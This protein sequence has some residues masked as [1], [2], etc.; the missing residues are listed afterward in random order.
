MNSV[1]CLSG[2]K[3]QSQAMRTSSTKNLKNNSG[4]ESSLSKDSLY[5]YLEQL[6]HWLVKNG[7]S[8]WDP[9]DLWD[10]SLGIWMMERKNFFQRMACSLTSRVEE[11]FPVIL[12]KVMRAKPSINTKAMGLFAAGFLELENSGS[13]LFLIEGEPGYVPCFSW[14][15][16]NRVE[17]YGGCGWG[18]PFDW[19]SR[20]LI[21]RHT[22][23]VVNSAIIGDAY[24]LWY[25]YLGNKRAL[26]RCE[27]VC[28]FILNGLNRS[29]PGRNQEF[30]FSYTPVDNFQV[31]NANLFG[32]E[33]LIRIGTELSR[34][35]WI[36]AGL[37]SARFSLK[38]IRKDGTLNYWSNEQTNKSIQ[39][40]TYH[41]GF[42][43]R[44][45][46]NIANITGDLEFRS[47]AD[48]YFTT[49][50][51]DYFSESGVP[52]FTRGNFD[53]IEVHSCAES[54]LCINKMFESGRLSK[55][56]LGWYVQNILNTAV[57][58]LWTPDGSEKGYFSWLIRKRLGIK[59]KVRIPMIRWG[60]A[61][62]FRALIDSLLT[63]NKA[64]D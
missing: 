64:F 34:E 32:A 47:A 50:I 40:D 29:A 20:I 2:K 56:Q 27:E 58:N 15:E 11:L 38:E 6:L 52:G 24:W 49:W 59:L 63:F 10:S 37:S 48:K 51:Q 43:I 19:R 61:W 25:K 8:G 17:K 33:F 22:P 14:L 16:E 9:Y 39:Q 55:N 18:Y 57:R 30:C 28:T 23:T 5:N 36:T 26:T 46:D 7:W 1:F 44:M 60:Q 4:N 53:V 41:S 54:L 35:N 12:R 45:L 42:E 62:M 31:H 3:I 13:K 21:P